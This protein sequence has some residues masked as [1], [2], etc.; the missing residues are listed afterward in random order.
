MAEGLVLVV[1]DDPHIRDICRLYLAQSGFGVAEA[2]NGEDA[3]DAISRLQPDLV[4]LD[5]MLPVQDGIQVL[6]EVRTRDQWLPVLMLT[7]LGEEEHRIQGLRLGADDYLTKPFSPREMVARAEAILRRA[8]LAAAGGVGGGDVIRV[9]GLTVDEPRR[10]AWRDGE[11][12]TLTPREFDLLLF[13]AA[14]PGRSWSRTQLLEQVWGFDFEGDER[15]VDVHVT[16]LRAKLERPDGY[17]YIHTVWGVGYRFA[18]E[19]A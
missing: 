5:I 10:Q 11:L 18:V 7:A 3:L 13:L 16:R 2:D 4:I 6:S 19:T 14:S 9:P 12:L 17:R 1:D 8:T 15:T